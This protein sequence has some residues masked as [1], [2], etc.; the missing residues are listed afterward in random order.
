MIIGHPLAND[1][2]FGY[3]ADAIFDSHKDLSL[4]QTIKLDQQLRK[5]GY[6]LATR[7]HLVAAYKKN[8]DGLI[9][10]LDHEIPILT[11]SLIDHDT[12]I[13][14]DNL[15][16]DSNGNIDLTKSDKRV[17]HNPDIGRIEGW[18]PQTAW[19]QIKE[20]S[21]ISSTY[22]VSK[23][24]SQPKKPGICEIKIRFDIDRRLIMQSYENEYDR[25]LPLAVYEFT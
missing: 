17:V 12:N 19:P 23:L 9:K 1:K 22:Y 14:Y 4:S 7:A 3:G 15:V 5:K 16:L 18:D 25:Y 24:S 13:L 8:R 10:M 20:G 11:L 21:G 2:G 6:K